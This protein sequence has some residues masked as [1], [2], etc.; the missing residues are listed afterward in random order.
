MC[1]AQKNLQFVPKWPSIGCQLV[2]KSMHIAAQKHSYWEIKAW[3]LAICSM[4][5]GQKMMSLILLFSISQF[6]FVKEN[7]L[8]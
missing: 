4:R 6:Y 7:E 2:I 3:Q 5:M 8:I 1:L